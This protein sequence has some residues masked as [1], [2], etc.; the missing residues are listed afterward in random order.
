M[1]GLQCIVM[2][3][4]IHAF[5]G[6]WPPEPLI[7]MWQRLWCKVGH[8]SE[9]FISIFLADIPLLESP[10]F[11]FLLLTWSLADVSRFQLYFLRTLDI[12]VP[13]WLL[14]MRYSDFIVQYP[15]VVLAEGW[16]VGS[17]YFPS[18]DCVRLLYVAV[19]VIIATSLASDEVSRAIYKSAA[20]NWWLLLYVVAA[21]AVSQFAYPGL[22]ANKSYLLFSSYAPIG[23]LFQL[24]EWVIFVPAYRVLWQVRERRLSAH[25]STAR[26]VDL[27]DTSCSMIAN[28]LNKEHRSASAEYNIIAAG[29]EADAI[30]IKHWRQ[31]WLDTIV[32]EDKTFLSD[33]DSRTQTFIDDARIRLSYQTFV[34]V[35]KKSSEIVA[36]ASCQVWDGP[37]PQVIRPSLQKFGSVWAVYVRPAHRNKGIALALMQQVK[38]HWKR[39]G[40]SAGLLLYVS[41]NGRR[42]YERLGFRSGNSLLYDFTEQ[43]IRPPTGEHIVE[44]ASAKD[45]Q[46]IVCNLN[47]L[48]KESGFAS[49]NFH[50]ECNQL[51]QRFIQEARGRHQFQAF[52]VRATRAE[53]GV[54]IGD[55]VGSVACHVWFGPIP[56]VLSDSF[57]KLGTLWGLY[58]HP[59]HRWKGIGRKLVS[60]C[61]D[62]WKSLGCTRGIVL[63]PVDSRTG[64]YRFFSRLGFAPSNAMVVDLTD[65]GEMVQAMRAKGVE[66]DDYYIKLLLR[67]L[68]AQLSATCGDEPRGRSLCENVWKVQR[69]YGTYIDPVENSF[70]RN[71]RRLGGNFDMIALAA[72]PSRLAAKFDALSG[73]YDVWTVGNKSVVEYW[74]S[75]IARAHAPRLHASGRILDVAC[76]IGLM[77]HQLRLA[78]YGGFIAGIDISS[79]MIHQARSREGVYDTTIVANVDEGLPPFLGTDSS[80]DVVLCTGAMELLNHRRVLAEFA[81][82][83]KP[84]GMLWIS[85]QALSQSGYNPTA[86]QNIKGISQEE[87]LAK[88]FEANFELSADLYETP[89]ELCEAAFETPSPAQDGTLLPVPYWFVCARTRKKEVYQ[90]CLS[91]GVASVK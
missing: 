72:D 69:Q 36:S 11:G 51:T 55:I 64:P 65:T 77:S 7:G 12:D 30:V 60:R 90:S 47:L 74:V 79:G 78:G 13:F 50:S 2:L 73:R 19:V 20:D 42:V 35:D 5:V 29:G 21:V 17:V 39:L 61:A 10:I 46:V 80:F 31:M 18:I 56:M 75:R 71:V 34:A 54:A 41:D 8:R 6:F 23:I 22:F 28:S 68:P 9:I 57:L 67:S 81:R 82:V 14:W 62:Y 32:K 24:Y 83:L 16:L 59:S 89:L 1:L 86:H 4:I 87:L 38:A 37:M 43:L 27:Q 45:D 88:L 85:F 40:C 76:G 48:M 70:T 63:L 66:G 44:K 33:F 52:V 84:D 25:T 26:A 53:G 58:V 91:T 3:D 49:E 15:M